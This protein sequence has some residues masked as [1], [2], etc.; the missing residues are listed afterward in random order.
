MISMIQKIIYTWISS[1]G[2]SD[3]FLPIDIW[4]PIYSLSILSLLIP[5]HYLNILTFVLSGIHFSYDIT[6]DLE[7]I[8]LFLFILIRYGQYRINQYFILSYMSLIH[9]PHHLMNISLNYSIF[10]TMTMTSIIFYN[11]DLL[12]NLINQ[13]IHSHYLLFTNIFI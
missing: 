9:V 7:D 6:V 8:Y 13:I 5:I 11:C 4:L 12:Q 2:I 10:L 1:H 3:I